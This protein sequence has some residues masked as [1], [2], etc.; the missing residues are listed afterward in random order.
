M[1]PIPLAARLRAAGLRWEPANG[2]AFVLPG[3]G[4]DDDVF[5]LSTMVVDVHDFPTGKV[6]GFNGTVEW[7][8]DS[9]EQ[10]QALW[11]P[12]EDQ[13]RSRLGGLF[14]RLER[15]GDGWTV[16]FALPGAPRDESVSAAATPEEAYAGALL[17]VLTSLEVAAHR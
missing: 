9:I 12:R 10:S 14:R 2:D 5:V 1:L 6:I 13:L 17:D 3:K 7:A 11:L 15:T 16:T 4:M 8:L